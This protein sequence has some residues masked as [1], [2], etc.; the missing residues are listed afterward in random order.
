MAPSHYLNQYCFIINWILRNKIQSNYIHKSNIFIQENAF[1]YV[2][3][4]MAAIC[5]GLNALKMSFKMADEISKKS[6]DTW[7]R[8]QCCSAKSDHFTDDIFY[9]VS[10]HILLN[11]QHNST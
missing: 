8:T 10:L 7:E 9:H 1:E 3:C 2:I 11:F 6:Q 4:E 5:L